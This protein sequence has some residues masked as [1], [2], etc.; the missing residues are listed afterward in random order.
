MRKPTLARQLKETHYYAFKLV[1]EKIEYGGIDAYSFSQTAYEEIEYLEEAASEDNMLRFDA[2]VCDIANNLFHSLKESR[3]GQGKPS[4]IE[5]EMKGV[6]LGM[7]Q[8]IIREC[9][10]QGNKSYGLSEDAFV[11]DIPMC[12]QIAWHFPSRCGLKAKE[13]DFAV[14]IKTVEYPNKKFLCEGLKKDEL[15]R[16][17]DRMSGVVNCQ[18]IEELNIFLYGEPDISEVLASQVNLPSEQDIILAEKSSNIN[19]NERSYQDRE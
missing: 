12:G 17:S 8:E 7:A 9:I 19:L 13:Y 14:E 3:N 18:S 10:S 4:Y 16:F 11:V 2:I 1:R 15:A 5:V 6:K